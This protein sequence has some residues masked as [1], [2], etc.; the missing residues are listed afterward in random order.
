MCENRNSVPLSAG[1]QSP[2][3]RPQSEGEMAP[4]LVWNQEIV[5]SIPT[6]L[7][8]V[9]CL[10]GHD[11]D[12]SF[13]KADGRRACAS[14]GW[15]GE[16]SRRSERTPTVSPLW[17]S[18]KTPACRAGTRRVRFPSAAREHSAYDRCIS[19]I[20]S[21]KGDGV[22]RRREDQPRAVSKRGRPW[23]GRNG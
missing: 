16:A 13:Q 1:K 11:R 3:R 23:E 18:G 17:S 4:H 20:C 2:V 7:T 21:T 10:Y 15:R 19:P 9:P 22:T 12:D 8:G 5:G 14:V 6:T